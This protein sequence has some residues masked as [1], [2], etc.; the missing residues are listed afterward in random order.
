MEKLNNYIYEVF[1]MMRVV[2]QNG[3]LVRPKELK[4]YW[5]DRKVLNN[6]YTLYHIYS[7]GISR[8]KFISMVKDYSVNADVNIIKAG[9]DLAIMLEKTMSK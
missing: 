4:L 7:M 3:L 8:R 5:K 2:Q 6:I 9:S 1:T